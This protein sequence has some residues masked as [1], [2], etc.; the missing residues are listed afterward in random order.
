M[1]NKKYLFYPF[2]SRSFGFITGMLAKNIDFEVIASKGSGLWGKDIAYSVNR[3][4]LGKDIKLIE[5]IDF[6]I[7][8][9]LIIS[10]YIE[11][12]SFKVELEK[13]LLESI[14]HNLEIVIL[15]E[16]WDYEFDF[17][18][19]YKNVIKYDN[20]QKK[21]IQRYIKKYEDL[22]LPFYANKCPVIFVGGILECMDN[23]NIALQIKV[24]LENIG[25]NT[26]LISD[27]QDSIFFQGLEYPNEFM[28]SNIDPVNQIIKIN[29]YI[30]AIEYIYFPDVI[31]L[32]QPKGMLM[33]NQYFH[34]TFGI[35]SYMMGQSVKA[36]Y[37]I[38]NI[39]ASLFNLEYLDVL[40][41]HFKKILGQEVNIFNITNEEYEV[42]NN[43]IGVLNPPIYA[44]YRKVDEIVN[45]VS[46]MD[47][48]IFNLNRENEINR[49]VNKIIEELSKED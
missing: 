8:D 22:N 23:F 15:A 5:E 46:K 12:K 29:R 28:N 35:Y 36:D 47:D 14:K 16:Q 32:H 48:S 21:L 34:N 19:G 38:L 42:G 43:T 1:N 25:Y 33:Y 41:N 37:L 44:D 2:I 9:T 4:S 26:V 20:S 24:R 27:E 6:N 40:S 18:N 3:P 39:P 17:I 13:L 45:K 49:I 11:D 31:I 10:S 7:Y 30:Q